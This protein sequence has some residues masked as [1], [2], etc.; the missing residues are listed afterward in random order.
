MSGPQFSTMEQARSFLYDI[1]HALFEIDEAVGDLKA[2]GLDVGALEVAAGELRLRLAAADVAAAELFRATQCAEVGPVGS[3]V[4]SVGH[5]G[6]HQ[7]NRFS[8]HGVRIGRNEWE[9]S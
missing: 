9:T 4:L 7:C 6:P 3:C 1:E 8:R 5:T 2:I